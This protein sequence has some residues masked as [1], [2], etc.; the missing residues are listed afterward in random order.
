MGTMALRAGG[1]G[2]GAAAAAALSTPQLFP[3]IISRSQRL[4]SY[5]LFLSFA[6]I[7]AGLGLDLLYYLG[8]LNT[9][10]KK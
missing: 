2:R 10:K 1:G 5:S 8:K 4:Y 7:P 6:M 9:K 3:R